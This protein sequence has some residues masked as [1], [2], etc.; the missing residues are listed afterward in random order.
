MKYLKQQAAFTLIE[1]IMVISLM[2]IISAMLA[3]MIGRQMA[4]YSDTASRIELIQEGERIL[5]I[6]TRDIRQ[7]L[8]YSIGVTRTDQIGFTPV[9][10][11]ARY[12]VAHGTHASSDILDF[13]QPDS[14]FQVL[15]S[16]NDFPGQYHMVVN[17]I[18]SAKID[19]LNVY[20]YDAP[21]GGALPEDSHVTTYGAN[22]ISRTADL[23]GD[24][25]NFSLPHRFSSESPT[26]KFYFVTGPIVYHCDPTL[27]RLIRYASRG[28]GRLPEAPNGGLIPSADLEIISTAITSCTFEY[29]VD[30]TAQQGLAIMTVNLA[31]KTQSI[32]LSRQVIVVNTP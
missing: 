2:G 22:L 17:H 27:G 9:L 13:S 8:P 21:A 11:A 30:N 7:S 16:V 23:D 6:M 15:G 29:S 20:A 14:S 28:F 3:N 5:D 26:H 19:G 1:I 10:Q 4:S 32:T 18:T 31:D 24:I 12:R 25:I